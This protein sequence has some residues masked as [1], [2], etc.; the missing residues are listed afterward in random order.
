[1]KLFDPQIFDPELFDVGVEVQGLFDP[2][3]FDPKIFDTGATHGWIL[4]I[5]EEQDLVQFS[6]NVEINGSF[7]IIEDQD[8]IQFGSKKAGGSVVGYYGINAIIERRLEKITG[9][10]YIQEED[11]EV[12]FQATVSHKARTA[13]LL[14]YEEPDTCIISIEH[15][16]FPEI[17]GLLSIIE[18]PDKSSFEIYTFHNE[19][20]EENEIL[21]LLMV[22]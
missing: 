21:M 22:A 9:R 5:T 10:F 1:M 17:N 11:D 4:N 7:N 20:Y 15:K 3:I 6:G 2:K 19:R 18:E 13:R 8:V 16:R 14:I 12:Y